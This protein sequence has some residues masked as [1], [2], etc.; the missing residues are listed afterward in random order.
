M[1]IRPGRAS[2]LSNPGGTGHAMEDLTV[3]VATTSKENLRMSVLPSRGIN[4]SKM[5]QNVAR[6]FEIAR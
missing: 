1:T 6:R 4:W 5:P 2:K 3:Q